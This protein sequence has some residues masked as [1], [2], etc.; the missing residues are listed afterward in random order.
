MNNIRRNKKVYDYL[1]QQV[2]RL[3][4]KMSITDIFSQFV[5]SNL[6]VVDSKEV[7]ELVINVIDQSAL[8]NDA[9]LME[10]L[11]LI[12]LMEVCVTEDELRLLLNRRSEIKYG[13][14][15]TDFDKILT[16]IMTVPNKE[17]DI[18]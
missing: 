1:Q 5:F 6:S 2:K 12:G 16:A 13:K 9:V 17:K 7:Y 14:D 15:L 4:W 10:T 18:I 11:K 8:D 3:D